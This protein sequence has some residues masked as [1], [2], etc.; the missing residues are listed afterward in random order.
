MSTIHLSL[1]IRGVLTNWSDDR[2]FGMFR[3]D[4]GHKMTAPEVKA[5][6]LEFLSRGYEYIPMGK[7]DNFDPKSGC[8]GHADAATPAQSKASES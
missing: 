3:H 4:D 6:L 7:C 2:F 5:E 1:D 8:R